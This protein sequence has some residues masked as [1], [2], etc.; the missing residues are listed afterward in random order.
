MREKGF[1][2]LEVLVVVAILGIIFLVLI[3]HLLCYL[4]KARVAKRITD[5]DVATTMVE[6][7]MLDAVIPPNTLEEVF[8]AANAPMPEGLHYCSAYNQDPDS[9][10]GNDCDFYDEQNPGQ[11]NPAAQTGMPQPVKFVIRTDRNLCTRCGDID[12]VWSTCC[13]GGP[14]VVKDGEWKGPLPGRIK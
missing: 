3:P 6:Q 1:T 2:L 11:S 13:G 9:G 5:V 8:A 14:Q 12:F 4:E 10:H 7:F